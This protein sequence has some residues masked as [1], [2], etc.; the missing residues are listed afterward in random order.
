MNKFIAITLAFMLMFSFSACQSK[1]ENDSGIQG[2]TV[3]NSGQV[4]VTFNV[5]NGKT[6][7]EVIGSNI[8]NENT[9]YVSYATGNSNSFYVYWYKVE[10]GGIL[11][12]NGDVYRYG[13][14]ASTSYA[15]GVSAPPNWVL[16]LSKP[17]DDEIFNPNDSEL[18]AEKYGIYLNF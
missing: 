2:V 3:T 11:S 8:G 7:E 4:A 1:Q 9:F 13:P 5:P 10:S 15:T 12:K 16:I 17:S 18:L 14:E 6:V